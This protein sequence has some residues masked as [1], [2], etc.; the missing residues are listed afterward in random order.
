MNLTKRNLKNQFITLLYLT[1]IL[2]CLLYMFEVKDVKIYLYSSVILTILVIIY[3]LWNRYTRDYIDNEEQKINFILE[4]FNHLVNYVVDFEV[5]YWNKKRIWKF[6]VTNIDISRPKKIKK[7]LWIISLDTRKVGYSKIFFYISEHLNSNTITL[8]KISDEELQTI[9]NNNNQLNKL[10][11][12][13]V[14]K[15]T[16]NGYEV[17]N[18]L[19]DDFLKKER[20]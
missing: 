3:N 18:I 17:I 6:K 9:I 19:N 11:D 1:F 7:D 20:F 16:Y 4:E 13:K 15:S 12:P 14:A 2:T 8:L 10:I 5:M